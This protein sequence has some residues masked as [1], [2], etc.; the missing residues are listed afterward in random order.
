M[1]LRRI[2]WDR[3]QWAGELPGLDT[4]A[5]PDVPQWTKFQWAGESAPT[6]GQMAYSERL[7]SDGPHGYSGRGVAD[8]GGQRWAPG[9]GGREPLVPPRVVDNVYDV[10]DEVA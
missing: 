1:D 8:S 2:A 4:S 3:T 9:I 6:D 10:D 5:E 7:A